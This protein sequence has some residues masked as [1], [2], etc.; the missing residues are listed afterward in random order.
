MVKCVVFDF[1]GT[2]VDSN[3]IKR[4]AFFEIAQPWDPS[5]SIVDDV[6]VRWPEANRSE[7]ARRI[8]EGLIHQGLLP[9]DASIED[10][11]TRLAE[12]YTARCETAIARCPVMPG[13]DEMLTELS[14]MELQLFVNS[15]TPLKPLQRL[16][17]L[18]NW[19]NIFQAAY[20][21]EDPKA[22]NLIQIARQTGA[23]P[24]EIVHVGDQLDD[25]RGAEQSGCH[26]IAMLADRAASSITDAALFIEDL[27]Q[28]PP[29]LKRIFG[30]AL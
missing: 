19:D 11:S 20:G 30:E 28:L 10:W 15:A 6:L 7:K 14:G 16:L 17:S 3:S 23:T 27:R 29:L 13:A 12:D 8:A 1:D 18:R 4:E 2:L 24:G 25:Q 21:A 26:F 9:T 5:R 22:D